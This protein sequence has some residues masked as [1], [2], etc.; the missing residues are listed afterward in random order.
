MEEDAAEVEEDAEDMGQSKSGKISAQTNQ[1]QIQWFYKSI[2]DYW[3]A[4]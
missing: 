1:I 4:L 3:A 2:T